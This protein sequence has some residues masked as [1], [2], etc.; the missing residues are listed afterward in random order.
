[1]K[2]RNPPITLSTLPAR[3]IYQAALPFT[4]HHPRPHPKTRKP[5]YP[6]A[7]IVYGYR[8][9]LLARVEQVEWLPVARVEAGVRQ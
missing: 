1:M 7:L 9:R 5:L 4:Q 2:R 6:K 8:G 3:T